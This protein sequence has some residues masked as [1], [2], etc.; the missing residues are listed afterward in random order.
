MGAVGDGLG[1]VKK[2]VNIEP[3]RLVTVSTPASRA[4]SAMAVAQT[5][6]RPLQAL[7]DGAVAQAAERGEARR[8]RQR[9][10]GERARLIDGAGGRDLLHD[11]APA[12]VGADG[13]AAADD[14]AERGEVGRDAVELLRAAAREAEAGHHLVED[15]Q[16]AVPL[17]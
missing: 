1:S 9:V 16:R 15:E 10:A 4:A 7:V 3:T 2:V 8:H 6:A 12:A 14:L 17:A 11:V 5:A 13:Q